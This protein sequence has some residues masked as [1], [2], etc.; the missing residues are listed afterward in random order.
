MGLHDR[1][2]AR[3]GNGETSPYDRWEAVYVLIAINVSVFVAD[4][5][6]QIFGSSR[7]DPFGRNAGNLIS[8]FF[9]LHVDQVARNPLNAWQLLT[10]GFVHDPNSVLHVLGNMLVLWFFGP[11]VE[12]RLG[13]REF[14][15]LYL[16]LLVFG[17]LVFF[18]HYWGM[19]TFQNDPL[20]LRA[21][22]L[23]ASGAVTG[24][25]VFYCLCYPHNQILFYG[26]IPV[27]AWVL[28]LI[29]VGSDLLGY[30]H[31]TGNTAYDVHLGGALLA[32]LYFQF[33][34]HLSSFLPQLP[35]F[36]LR[37]G[38]WS[39]PRDP[40]PQRSKPRLYEPPEEKPKAVAEDNDAEMDRLLE[41]ISRRGFNSLT[42]EEQ[43]YLENASRKAREKRQ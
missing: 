11:A 27:P 8:D 30:L 38:E 43:A 12:N 29:Y 10:A 22:C 16:T 13:R 42:A 18:L 33:H 4:M 34:W 32:A 23:G 2:Y 31:N 17:N 26:I 9:M 1:H 6:M 37:P 36:S 40:L 20:A 28:G 7:T 14:T 5:L 21:S 35:R 41:K 19:A 15:T 3:V 39:S 24:I 25:V